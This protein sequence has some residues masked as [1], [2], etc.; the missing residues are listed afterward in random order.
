MTNMSPTPESWRRLYDLAGQVKQLSPWE[1]MT[2]EDL[3]GVADPDSDTVMFVSVMSM[4][5]EHT[6]VSAYLGE[7]ALYD[8]WISMRTH[9]KP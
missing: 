9:Q 3:F 2:E 8:F 6:S 7:A 5:G 4:L 1:W